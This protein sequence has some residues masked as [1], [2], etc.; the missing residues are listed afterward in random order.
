V[1]RESEV[2]QGFIKRPRLLQ[3]TVKSAALPW[4]GTRQGSRLPSRCE[5][6]VI[7]Q[8]ELGGRSK[9]NRHTSIA[10]EVR[11]SLWIGV[12]DNLGPAFERVDL[13]GPPVKLCC[14]LK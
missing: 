3:A 14:C 10:P 9:I 1:G 7:A 2:G 6:F 8:E 4:V 13:I 5:V 11:P 12:G